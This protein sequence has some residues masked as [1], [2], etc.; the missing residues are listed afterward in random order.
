MGCG[1]WIETTGH[2]CAGTQHPATTDAHL[3]G[4]LAAVTRERDALTTDSVLLHNDRD[5]WKMRAEAAEREL[6]SERA[7]HRR[8]Q[9]YFER[10]L[11]EERKRREE[12][13]A[14]CDF[15]RT[16]ACQSDARREVAEAR[17]REL[18]AGAAA[19]RRTLETIRENAIAALSNETTAAF[20]AWSRVVVDAA[21]RTDAGKQMLARLEAAERVVEAAR[22]WDEAAKGTIGDFSRAE[23]ALT[24]AIRAHDAA[25]N[26]ARGEESK[27]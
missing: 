19:L 25:V 10:E 7:A 3:R 16:A 21:L 5:G 24:Q 26:A 17:V 22:D 4:L 12:A 9:A 6:A 23:N 2:L 1:K 11:A 8:T 14:E 15:Q 27:P 20:A 13:E 18:E